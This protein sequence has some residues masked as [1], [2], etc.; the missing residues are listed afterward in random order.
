MVHTGMKI[1]WA[2]KQK[3]LPVAKVKGTKTCFRWSPFIIDYMSACKSQMVFLG[4]DFGSDKP[5]IKAEK[6]ESND[7]FTVTKIKVN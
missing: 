1:I 6:I 7:G 5:R 2:Q 3:L 4:L